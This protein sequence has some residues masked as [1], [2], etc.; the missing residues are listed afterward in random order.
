MALT[1][2]DLRRGWAPASEHQ[3]AA[4]ARAACN[5]PRIRVPAPPGPGVVEGGLLPLPRLA[6]RL[7]PDARLQWLLGE[8]EA[9]VA[10]P[11]A[12][13]CA[14][15]G[16]D[17]DWLAAIVRRKIATSFESDPDTGRDP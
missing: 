7:P 16:I 17:P 15:V 10:V 11:V 13:A 4:R 2:G 6:L 14:T 3:R 9:D 1:V 8:L 5:F 12:V